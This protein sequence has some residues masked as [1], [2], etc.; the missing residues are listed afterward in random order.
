MRQTRLRRLTPSPFTTCT[1]C[2]KF[3]AFAPT[4]SDAYVAFWSV[5]V[6]L[7]RRGTE[8][9]FAQDS[10]GRIPCAPDRRVLASDAAAPRERHDHPRDRH[11]NSG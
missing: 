3:T 6:A 7:N 9:M 1:D 5:S 11:G 4:A 8:S 10:D 2:W